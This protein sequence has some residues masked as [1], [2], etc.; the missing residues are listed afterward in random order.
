MRPKLK[1]T[2]RGKESDIIAVIGLVADLDVD[3]GKTGEMPVEPSF[4]IETSPGN[5]QPVVLFDAPVSPQKAKELA[6]ALCV[7][8]GGD[9]GTKDITHVWRV[10]G[11]LN[12]PTV[13]K[14][15][16]GR[17]EDPVPV[18]LSQP[19]EGLLHT[20]EA[21]T[22]VLGPHIKAAKEV[23]P[24]SFAGNVETG[25]LLERLRGRFERG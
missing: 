9:T 18:A 3:T 23:K 10:P 7:A 13:T 11:T 4:V 6:N 15:A 17:A 2:S 1:R 20:A 5:S 16:R 14:L 19:F 25:P 12:H 8:T 21:L 24:V 22:E